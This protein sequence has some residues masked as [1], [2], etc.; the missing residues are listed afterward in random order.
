MTRGIADGLETVDVTLPPGWASHGSFFAQYFLWQV[1]K[2]IA[3][4]FQ[5]R[6]CVLL[7]SP[8]YAPL[9]GKLRKDFSLISYTADDYRSYKGWGGNSVV[10][11][12]LRIQTIADL[13]VFVSE[14][15]RNRAVKEFALSR[16]QTLVSANATEPRFSDRRALMPA[17]LVGRPGPIVGILGG[18]SDRLDLDVVAR[19]ASSPLIGTFLV[20][21]PISEGLVDRF[22][23]FRNKNVVISGYIPHSE[24]HRYAQAMDAALI[25]Y[26]KTDLNYFCSPMRLY[27][28]LATGV[29]I[30][31]SESCNQINISDFA[32][33]IV[34]PSEM[35][36]AEL[37]LAIKTGLPL[38]STSPD[39][40]YWESRASQLLA[41]IS[42]I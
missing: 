24:M 5:K 21:G 4:R 30:F 17:E 13:A 25:L 22:P 19:V 20:A 7:S 38:K 34:R 15:L 1:I 27:D 3:K 37:D 2:R 14:A 10:E 40:Y 39:H 26:A 12:E 31:A 28:H 6:P 41:A 18:I 11:K 8:A 9:A 16:K 42:S 23:V 36:P 35:I 32:N 29:P 33:V